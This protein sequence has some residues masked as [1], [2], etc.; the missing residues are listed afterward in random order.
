MEPI[1]TRDKILNAALDLFSTG[2]YE[3]VS[4]KQIAAAVGI[5]DSSLYKHFPASSRFSTR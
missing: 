1:P 3:G 5:K 4:V 2:G